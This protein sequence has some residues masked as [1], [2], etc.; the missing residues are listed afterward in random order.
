MELTHKEQQ[1]LKV[2]AAA[3]R[4]R[5]AAKDLQMAQTTFNE[6]TH[7]LQ[8]A[9]DELA[10]ATDEL[11]RLVAPSGL[12][13]ED[14]G[15]GSETTYTNSAEPANSNRSEETPNPA[16]EAPVKY[17]VVL[18]LHEHS[19]N[20]THQEIAAAIGTTAGTARW[21]CGE[22]AKDGKISKPADN[23]YAAL[24]EQH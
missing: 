10:G 17:R 7:K 15:I 12:P 19:G 9:K 23:Q 18:Y 3:D 4:Y 16:P 2:L 14:G 22:L 21:A 8:L 11:D 20:H 1:R 6:A 24:T 5:R 13:P